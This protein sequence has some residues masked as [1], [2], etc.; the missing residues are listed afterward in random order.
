MLGEGVADIAPPV[1]AEPVYSPRVE[2]CVRRGVDLWMRGGPTDAAGCHGDVG[3][4]GIRGDVRL[5]DGERGHERHRRRDCGGLDLVGTGL[6]H[7]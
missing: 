2:V 1:A 5:E 4:I 3:G 6:G 7:E